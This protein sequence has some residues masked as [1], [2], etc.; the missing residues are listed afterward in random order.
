MFH[1]KHFGK[2]GPE[3][4]TSPHTEGRLWLVESRKNLVLL[5]A[6]S[7]KKP[8]ASCAKV[9][10]ISK[11]STILQLRPFV[12]TMGLQGGFCHGDRYDCTS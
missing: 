5:R 11:I 3:N 12:A 7:P 6:A 1:V 8:G 2:V 10:K 4:L 9:P